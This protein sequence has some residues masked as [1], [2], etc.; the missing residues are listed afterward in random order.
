MKLVLNIAKT[1]VVINFTDQTDKARLLCTRF[2]RGFIKSDKRLNAEA[3]LSVLRRPVNRRYIKK[4]AGGRV[5]EKLIPVQDIAEWLKDIHGHR[6]DFPL[7]EK[8]ICS[9]CLNGLLLFDTKTSAGRIYLLKEGDGFSQPLYR[10]IWIYLSQVL[11]ERRGCFIHAA[12][13]VKDGKGHLFIG[14]SGSGKSSIAREL[15]QEY[16]VFSDDSPILCSENGKQR[17]Y[18]SPYHQ[19]DPSNGLDE[20]VLKMSAEIRGFYFLVKDKKVF[21]DRVSRQETFSMILMKYIHFFHYLSTKAKTSL[22]DLF[23]DACYKLPA[24]YLHFQLDKD[25]WKVINTK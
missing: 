23:F 7:N 19:M 14:D 6:I 17:L 8:T 5:F 4:I 12:A 11:G 16:Q 24:Y 9:F 22:F 21:L 25:L 10:L 3:E 2:F 20:K 13:L 15:G 18:P 1:N